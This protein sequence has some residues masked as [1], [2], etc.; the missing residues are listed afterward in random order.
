M[1]TLRT[2][3]EDT[4]GEDIRVAYRHFALS[5]HDKAP[6]TGEAVEAAG[7]QGR[8]WEMH[9]L[10]YERQQEWGQLSGDALSEKLAEYAEDL[11]LDAERFSRELDEHVYL[12][13][14]EAQTDI[15]TQAGLPGTP[16]YIINGVVSEEDGEEIQVS[17]RAVIIGSGGYANN[18]EWIKKYTGWEL[19]VNV[20]PVGNVDKTGDGIRM[21][22]EVGAGNEGLG[23][24]ELLVR[25]QLGVLVAD[26]Q[27][28]VEQPASL[29]AVGS[30]LGRGCLARAERRLGALF[31]GQVGGLIDDQQR[32][33]F[34]HPFAFEDAQVDDSA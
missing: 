1:A 30:R 4:Y 25:Y 9:D 13:K 12:E 29:I 14:V 18:K 8:F 24:L 15:A 21:A 16:S 17:A 33:P 20:V 7:A 11:G 2:Y 19:D 3:L 31:R 5:F 10:L 32:I 22:Y 34:G 26:A 27:R 23:V 28:A 6:I